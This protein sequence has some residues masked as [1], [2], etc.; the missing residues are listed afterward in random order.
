MYK[1]LFFIISIFL[2]G[3][4]IFCQDYFP[5]EVGN[6]WT[7][8]IFHNDVSDGLQNYIVTHDSIF[9]NG[10]KYYEI[11]RIDATQL[12]YVRVDSDF[13]Y[14]YNIYDSLEVA[15]YKLKAGLNETWDA[16]ISIFMIIIFGGSQKEM[17]FND[18]TFVNNYGLDGLSTGE[19]RISRKYGPIYSVDYGDPGVPFKTAFKKILKGCII[20]GKKYGTTVGIKENLFQQPDYILLSNYPNPFNPTT[21]IKYYLPESDFIQLNVYNTI[22][23]KIKTLFSGYKSSGYYITKFNG[24]NL[25]SGLYIVLLETSE[26]IKTCKIILQK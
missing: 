7:Y 13:I 17:L 1:R 6:L 21:T 9:P 25:A 24:S 14:F 4:P 10:K 16:N 23:Q 20:S 22:G 11:N 2:I 3:Y 15:A 5:L 12:N 8:E 19:M 26:T 18:S